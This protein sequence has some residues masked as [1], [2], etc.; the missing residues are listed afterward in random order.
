MDRGDPCSL[1]QLLLRWLRSV[2]EASP[3][4]LLLRGPPICLVVRDAAESLRLSPIPNSG[5]NSFGSVLCLGG[6]LPALPSSQKEL[7]LG[8]LSLH[9]D[10]TESVSLRD[11]QVLIPEAVNVSF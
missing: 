9:R 5:C 2:S 11:I 6:P 8:G 4:L 10:F 7:P 3:G 1:R